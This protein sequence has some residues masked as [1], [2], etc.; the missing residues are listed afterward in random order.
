MEK[1]DY[2]KFN[3]MVVK[4]TYKTIYAGERTSIAS[5]VQHDDRFDL[6]HPYDVTK[7]NIGCGR[8]AN[9]LIEDIVSISPITEDEFQ[10]WKSAYIKFHR[11]VVDD[12]GYDAC[13][14]N[15]DSIK[16]LFKM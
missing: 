16:P 12:K 4:I 1:Q 7:K 9:Y 10:T 15:I 13:E 3:K 6:G 2:T 5:F 8:C 11:E 14:E